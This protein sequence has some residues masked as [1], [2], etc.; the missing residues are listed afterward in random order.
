VVADLWQPLRCATVG[1]PGV[2]HDQ[3][4]HG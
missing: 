1:C 4:F 3:K 2:E